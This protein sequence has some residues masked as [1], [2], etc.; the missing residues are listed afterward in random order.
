MVKKS[1]MAVLC[2]AGI[3]L[4]SLGGCVGYDVVG[5][6]GREPGFKNANS[7]AVHNIMAE[8][9][10]WTVTR[11]PP[12]ERAEWDAGP[13]SLGNRIPIEGDEVFAVNLPPGTR[14]EVYLMVVSKAGPGA[15]PMAPGR[16]AMPTYHVSRVWVGGDEA[17]VDVIRPV[18]GLYAGE[19]TGGEP[20]TQGISL[21]LRG[22]VRPW[23]V[24]S[25]NMWTLGAMEVPPLCYV[26]EAPPPLAGYPGWKETPRE[27]PAS[28]P[29]NFEEFQTPP[30][31][32]V[33]DPGA[34]LEAPMTEPAPAEPPAGE[35]TPQ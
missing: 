26:P 23:R 21:R 33:Q 2:V 11:Y 31:Q 27:E 7:P 20:A 1:T 15:V 9:V 29:E 10:R 24:T 4:G 16:E 22:G 8:A 5:E 3:A 30:E 18:P 17:R 35:P 28:M 14:R 12:Y 19:A 6:T 34:P 25:H 32:P 13:T